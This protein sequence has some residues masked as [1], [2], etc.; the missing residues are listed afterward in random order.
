MW[1]K[2]LKL[3]QFRN[4]KDK[5]FH[6]DKGLNLIHGN[7][8][9]GKSSLLEAIYLLSL[10]KS[11]RVSSETSLLHQTAASLFIKG[12]FQKKQDS[13]L[14]IIFS[15]DKKKQI[16]INQK[17][18]H[19]LSE[20]IGN[21]NVV[22]FLHRDIELIERTPEIRRRMMDILFSQINPQYYITLMKYYKILHQ[23]NY[24]LKSNQHNI[25]LYEAL[26]KN[27]W[28]Y[29]SEIIFWRIKYIN[30]FI[31]LFYDKINQYPMSKFQ[32]YQILYYSRG[33][34]NREKPWTRNEIEEM[35]KELL[36]QAKTE[37][38]K[39]RFTVIGP[40]RDDVLF[41]NEEQ[42]KLTDYSSTG[43]KRLLVL[44]L[45]MAEI[46]FISKYKKE[47]P[48]ILMDDIVL[49]LD[50]AHTDMLL[51]YINSIENQALI[52]TVDD[53]EYKKLNYGNKIQL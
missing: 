27:L 1:I 37:E 31:K 43:E 16:K 38:E 25:V 21:I 53:R 48:I 5:E 51:Q 44:F 13:N 50:E 35:F 33:I 19:K 29:G 32:S 6:F 49:D 39:Y 15:Y 4:Y 11:F 14:E 2:T 18:I 46:D 26:N 23:R 9:S 30:E 36:S 24:Y 3:Y 47:N 40:H 52:T 8:G 7:N 45:K 28:E 10:G 20:L 42:K 12:I 34:K 17:N 41:L 22:L